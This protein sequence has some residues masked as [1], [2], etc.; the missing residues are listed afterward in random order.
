MM[1]AK[2]RSRE[3]K[4]KSEEENPDPSQ[5][6]LAVTLLFSSLV[7]QHRELALHFVTCPPLPFSSRLRVFALII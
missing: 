6:A 3:E 2:T 7:G 5:K 4:N 1:G